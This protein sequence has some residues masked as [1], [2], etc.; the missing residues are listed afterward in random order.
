M[1]GKPHDKKTKKAVVAD[2]RAG[3]LKQ[4]EIAKK[5][6]VSENTVSN[7][8]MQHVKNKKP[9]RA[10]ADAKAQAEI[11]LLQ[12]EIERLKEL[13]RMAMGL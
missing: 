4:C 2:L 12:G 11:M 9:M 8:N 6:G 5:H 1:Q 3:E 10:K 13:L 7:W